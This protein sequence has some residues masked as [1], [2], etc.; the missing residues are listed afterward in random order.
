MSDIHSAL[1]SRKI[2]FLCYS[3]KL[4]VNLPEREQELLPDRDAISRMAYEKQYGKMLRAG[5]QTRS[6]SPTPLR[7]QT[8]HPRGERRA[9]RN[10]HWI[11]DPVPASLWALRKYLEDM[12][13]G[14][15]VALPAYGCGW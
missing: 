2:Y 3:R 15:T 9:I 6:R 12:K 8:R 1:V 13:K 10:V 7:L 11:S 4:H 5:M 14:G